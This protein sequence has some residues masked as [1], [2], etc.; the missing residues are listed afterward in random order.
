MFKIVL[1]IIL[2]DRAMEEML[3][4]NFLERWLKILADW[5]V[6]ELPSIILLIILLTVSLRLITFFI[7]RM[8]KLL[9]KRTLAHPDGPDM[10]AEKRLH[11]LMGILKKG[12]FVVIWLVFIMIFLK[13]FNIDIAPI[14]AGAG[15]IGLAVGFG[16]QEL[17]RDFISGFFILLEN[18]IRMGDV[19]ILNGTAGVVEDIQLRTVTLRDQSGTVHVFQN[20]K[21]NTIANMTKGWSAMVF[22]IGVAYKEDLTKVM[23]VM[24]EVAEELRADEDF[25]Q[26]ILDPMEIYGLDNFGNSA[27]IVKGRIKTK[28]GDQWTIGRE[29][30]KRLKEAFDKNHIEIPFPH[31]T[32]YWGE[33]ITPLKLDVRQEQNETKAV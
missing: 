20:G 3:T 33:D 26:K 27:L 18:Q 2:F 8:R 15:I 12:S 1:I 11:T 9:Q 21:I 4:N 5:T 22:D 31:Q 17:V 23:K 6:N 24:K 29:Y 30:R 14:L 13:K 25:K 10:E 16:A 7:N 28:P 32:I 19:V